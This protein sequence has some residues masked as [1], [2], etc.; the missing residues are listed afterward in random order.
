MFEYGLATMII[1]LAAAF[2]KI[3][4]SHINSLPIKVESYKVNEYMALK[5]KE[6]SIK[7]N[8]LLSDRPVP[9]YLGNDLSYIT[10]KLNHFDEK[11]EDLKNLADDSLSA[12]GYSRNQISAIRNFDRTDK[13]REAASPE[14]IGEL[15][16]CRKYSKSKDNTTFK[17]VVDFCWNGAPLIDTG[18]F[19]SVEGITRSGN[20]HVSDAVTS[21]H[22][23][24]SNGKMVKSHKAVWKPEETIRG[25]EVAFTAPVKRIFKMDT[26]WEGSLRKGTIIYEAIADS[27]IRE[28]DAIVKYSHT[29]SEMTEGLE[30][31][32]TTSEKYGDMAINP[33]CNI[34]ELYG[35]SIAK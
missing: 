13:M 20:V 2:L 10:E 29:G 27:N 14:M 3:A 24:D 16:I 1:L 25:M 33:L 35:S 32:W 11:I 6:R 28:V 22:Y 9:E 17:I 15:T 30:Y 21:L 5:E 31:A 34:G 18:D 8:I 26:E 12:R 4:Y 23:C 7:R 19:Y